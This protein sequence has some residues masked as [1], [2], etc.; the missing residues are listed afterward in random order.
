MIAMFNPAR[1]YWPGLSL[2][3]LALALHATGD[4]TTKGLADRAATVTRLTKTVENYSISM[5]DDQERPLDLQKKPVLHYSDTISPVT[6]GL[7]FVWTKAGRPEAVMALHPGSQGYTWIE[8]KSL[9]LSPLVATH[10][11]RVEWTPRTAGVDFQPLDDAAAPDATEGKRL[12]QMRS[13]LRPFTASVWD[14]VNGTQPLRLLPQPLLRYAQPE[15]GIL[16]GALFAFVLSTN[17]ELLLVVEAQTMDDKPRWMY[18]IA[19]F[20][21]R[22]TELRFQ[23]QQIWTSTGLPSTKNPSAT[24]FQLRALI[25]D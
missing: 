23:D 24:F 18:S 2:V 8:F 13:M 4:E 6:D 19:R 22:Q 15:R 9:S 1:R 12:T 21:G 16:D 20:T 17:P 11:G 7:V 10:Q 25:A 3:V 5:D 14:N